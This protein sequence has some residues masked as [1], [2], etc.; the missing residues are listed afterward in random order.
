M[1]CQCGSTYRRERAPTYCAQLVVEPYV[2]T[3]QPFDGLYRS[4]LVLCP[5]E[6]AC[7]MAC[8]VPVAAHTLRR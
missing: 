8:R 6:N 7:L 1:G 5:F 3:K 4:G 2:S